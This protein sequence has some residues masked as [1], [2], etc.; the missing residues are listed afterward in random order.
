[1]PET[2]T[3]RRS[4]TLS[5]SREEIEPIAIAVSAHFERES[6]RIYPDDV[7]VRAIASWLE[8]RLDAIRDDMPDLLTSPERS[9]THE[10]RRHLEE[11]AKRTEAMAQAAAAVQPNVFSG[12]RIFSFEK[13]A[14]MTAYIASKGKEVYKTKLNKLLFYSDFVNYYLSGRSISGSRYVHLPFGP[15]PDGYENFLQTFSAAGTIRIE[16]GPNHE[17]IMAGQEPVVDKLTN[18]EIETLDWVL[19]NY[20]HLSAN[21]ISEQSHREKAYRFT[22][23]GEE[24]AYEYAK[25][26]EKL[27][28]R[29][30]N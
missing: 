19:A 7:V 21:Q 10:F 6:G 24:I 28:L 11:S 27:P 16:H 2:G 26:F 30:D 29:K 1:M 23:T 4:V 12:N 25:L 22:R 5:L 20:G 13:L 9:E 17:V 15:V 3:E 18:E 8:S 14:A